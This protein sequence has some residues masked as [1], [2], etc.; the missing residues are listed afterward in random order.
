MAPN[1]TPQGAAN[2]TP[3]PMGNT[4][5]SASIP[6]CHSL[7]RGASNCKA[8]Q[9]TVEVAMST[10]APKLTDD[11]LRNGNPKKSANKGTM[12]TP[13]PSPVMAETTPLNKP[14]ANK[15]CHGVS[16]ICDGALS[17]L[18]NMRTTNGSKMMVK[19]I[20]KVFF[21]NQTA[22]SS[23]TLVNKAVDAPDKPTQSTSRRWKLPS[24]Y[25]FQEPLRPEIK[26]KNKE[27]P[28]MK[29]T[30]GTPKC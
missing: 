16:G 12:T 2:I 29:V 4:A 23:R 25:C 19:T 17:F 1:R 22:C 9:L 27:L 24:L 3:M 15:Y 30:N 28:M 13:P 11:A 10:M 5:G 14:I 8:Y 21:S 18:K 6:N 26:V 20:E 7:N